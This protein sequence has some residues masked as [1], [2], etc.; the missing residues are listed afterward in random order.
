M[1]GIELKELKLNVIEVSSAKEALE[2]IEDNKSISMVLT[3]YEMPKMNG[4]EL[5][6]A[7]RAPLK[8]TQI[9]KKAKFR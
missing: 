9:N 3:D 5:T 4:I 6:I 2:V 8:T 1:L 7:L